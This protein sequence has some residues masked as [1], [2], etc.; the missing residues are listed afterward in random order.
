[1]SPESVDLSPATLTE[2][3]RASGVLRHANVVVADAEQIGAELG[4]NGLLYRVT[5][6]YDREEAGVPQSL[7]AKF[8]LGADVA[9]KLHAESRFYSEFGGRIGIRMPKAYAAEPHC[10][11]LEDLS[12]L[13]CGDVVA[14]CS[15]DE[16]RLVLRHLAKFHAAGWCNPSFS[17]LDWLPK[18]PINPK[19]WYA[20]FQEYHPRFLERFDT[21]LTEEMRQ[22]TLSLVDRMPAIIEELSDA[23][24]TLIHVD[25]HLDNILF[26]P[27]DGVV[28]LDWP[29]AAIGPAA[30][31]VVR[32]VA[33]SL[34]LSENPSTIQHLTKEYTN[35]LHE[36]GVADYSSAQFGRHLQLAGCRLW[37]GM[38]TGYGARDTIELESRQGAL[39]QTEIDRMTQMC[40]TSGWTETA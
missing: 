10:L 4:F 29:S 11:L 5:L 35:K 38:V 24:S 12:D 8:A 30:I 20:R 39:Q 9:D 2:A 33:S 34:S 6:T 16:A 37:A 25:T 7:I 14:G 15:L 27:P 19:R 22:F 23:P 40:R 32:F 36:H 18:W 1:M 31:D 21:L 13:K 3:L 26:D 28:L 17:Q